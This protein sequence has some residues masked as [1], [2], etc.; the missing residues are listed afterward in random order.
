MATAAVDFAGH[1]LILSGSPGAGKTTLARRLAA[2]PGSSKAHLHADDFFHA[3]KHGAISPYRPEAHARNAVVIEALAA[4]A[5]AYAAGG[6]LT[7]VDGVIGP[8]FLAAFRRLAAPVHYLVLQPPLEAAIARCRERGYGLADASAVAALHAQL[9]DLGELRAHALATGE[10]TPE[11]ALE[12]VVD[13]LASGA[14]ALP[15]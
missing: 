13:A 4:A 8:W 6:L 14:F 2:L 1:I 15:R 9:A 3:I 7:I 5:Q 12:R 11:Q 10:A